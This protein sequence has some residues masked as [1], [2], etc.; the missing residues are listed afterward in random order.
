MAFERN[1]DGRSKSEISRLIVEKLLSVENMKNIRILWRPTGKPFLP[2]DPAEP[3]NR[4]N[5]NNGSDNDND[6]RYY[7]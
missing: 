3:C 4:W 6:S 1:D 5:N 2:G 7:K